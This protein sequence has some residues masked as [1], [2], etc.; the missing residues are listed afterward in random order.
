ME[1]VKVAIQ[2][3][4]KLKVCD[5]KGTNMVFN[6]ETSYFATLDEQT[7]VKAFVSMH[8]INIHRIVA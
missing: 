6:M 4:P 7:V 2:A 5:P 3:K 1:T 8:Q